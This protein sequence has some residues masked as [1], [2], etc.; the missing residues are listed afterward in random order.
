MAFYES[1]KSALSRRRF[2]RRIQTLGLGLFVACPSILMARTPPAET[3]TYVVLGQSGP[4]GAMTS[5]ENGR[6]VH[7]HYAFSTNGRGPTFDYDTT[8]DERG[9]PKALQLNGTNFIN[10][11]VTESFATTGKTTHWKTS[12]DEGHGAIGSFYLPL[13]DSPGIHALL[14]RAL[15]AASPDGLPLAPGGRAKIEPSVRSEVNVDGTPRKIQLYFLSGVDLSRI[16]IWLDEQHRLFALI[17][18]NDATIIESA[19]ASAPAL[20]QLQAKAIDAHDVALAAELSEGAPGA[21]LIKQSR[22]F[23][24]IA[25]VALPATDVL[26]VGNRIIAIGT[27][28][29]RLAPAGAKTID[30]RG[31]TLLPGLWD[32]HFHTRSSGDGLLNLANGVL[33][34]RD[35][36]GD[37]EAAI[38][39]RRRFASGELLGPRM[40]LAGLIEGKSATATD[41]VHVSTAEELSRA[42]TMFEDNGYDEIKIYSSFPAALLP[43]AVREAHGRGLRIGGHVP[44][45]LRMDDVVKLGFDDVSHFNFAFLNFLGD[46]VQKRTNTLARM[47]EPAARG[48]AIDLDSREVMASVALWR[49][50]GIVLDSTALVLEHLFTGKLGVLDPAFGG[51]GGRLPPTV[52][53]N[54]L[55]GG[56][57]KT[58]EQRLLY[59]R[60]FEHVLPLLKI[61]HDQGI[62]I[63]P[64]TDG[65]AGI[66]LVRE[67][68]LY[69]K[70]GIPA[71][72][73]LQMATLVPAQMMKLDSE[74]GSV[75]VGKLADLI[76]V[77]GDPTRDISTLRNVRTV[78]RNGI[79]LDG[80]ALQAAAGIQPVAANAGGTKTAMKL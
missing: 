24:A 79:L 23:D 78:I 68:E 16:A 26:V 54:G 48:Y 67:L 71:G 27:D 70:A 66:L 18:P 39:W 10:V 57:A 8:L 46:E 17:T 49:S 21:I 3:V 43:Q 73:A 80:A 12:V 29:A 58:E 22:V 74:S 61:M 32:M 64:G 6:Q 76:L 9:L 28:A 72:D 41:G 52:T 14:A 47:L 7:I 62:A 50:H 44:V 51:F 59:T 42:I 63:V 30:A 15:L 20:R 56:L 55:V 31:Q 75:T 45:G 2:G 65:A 4:M 11:P 5:R 25:K 38:D 37:P 40:F 33:T 35:M 19:A 60:S 77:E 13:N 69:V 36:G 53:R 34:V 1:S